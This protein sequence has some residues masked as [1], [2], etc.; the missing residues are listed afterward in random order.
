MPGRLAFNGVSMRQGVSLV[1]VQVGVEW[2]RNYV[3]KTK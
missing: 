3:F 2:R 1:W